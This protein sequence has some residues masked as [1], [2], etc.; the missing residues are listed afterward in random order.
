MYHFCTYFDQYYL[1]RGLALY[2]SLRN[3]CSS[4]MLWVLC[5]DRVCYSVLSQLSLPGLSPILIDDFERDDERLLKT[6]KNR[7]RIEYYF[8]CTPSL[9]LYIFKSQP[10]ISMI[11]YL[12]ADLFFF[13]NPSP[14]FDEIADNSIAIIGHRYARR[15][16]RR[17]RYGA[18]NVGWISFRGDK[19]GLACLNW[20][21]ER[22]LEWC[23]DRFEEGRFADQKYLDDW[24]ALFQKLVV[25]RHKGANLAPWNIGNYRVRYHDNKIWVDEQPL[26]FFH[27]HGLRQLTP[28]LYDSNFAGSRAKLCKVTRQYI[29]AQYIYTLSELRR[30]YLPLASKDMLPTGKRIE[31]KTTASNQRIWNMFDE[32]ACALLSLI[33]RNYLFVRNGHVL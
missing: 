9:P 28:W 4:F 15:L 2:A 6:K 25:L 31:L 27:F 18:Y 33:S 17:Y 7:S 32:A 8:T 24:P 16:N 29:F 20:W 21:R 23:Y 19:N 10:E 5:M 1:P 22:C 11:S 14:L 12:D 13:D 3:H 30:L 26:I